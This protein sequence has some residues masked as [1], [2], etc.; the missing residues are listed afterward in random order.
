MKFTLTFLVTGCCKRGKESKSFSEFFPPSAGFEKLRMD[1][2]DSDNSDTEV[3]EFAV[4]SYRKS[5]SA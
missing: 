2:T 1:E 3:E 4:S 5:L